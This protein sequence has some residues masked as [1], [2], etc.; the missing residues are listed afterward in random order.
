MQV[1]G[2][3]ELLEYAAALKICG[4]QLQKAS[5]DGDLDIWDVRHVPAIMSAV[6]TAVEGT[7]IAK[8][9]L[10]DLSAEEMQ[11]VITAFLEGGKEMIDG[12]NGV[13]GTLKK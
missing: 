7:D 12:V 8:L 9:E 13:I 11:V 6:K 3:K 5:E 4:E 2:T 10:A 1:H